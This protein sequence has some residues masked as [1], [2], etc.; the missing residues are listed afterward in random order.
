MTDSNINQ[1][2]GTYAANSFMYAN[3]ELTQGVE[4]LHDIATLALRLISESNYQRLIVT[5]LNDED[6]TPTVSRIQS[7]AEALALRGTH[8]DGP[9]MNC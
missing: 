4:E 2:K 6:L 1:P 8:Q 5:G 9:I 7:R 3:F